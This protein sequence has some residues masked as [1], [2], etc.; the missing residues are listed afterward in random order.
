MASREDAAG[1]QAE[2]F[3]S[4]ARP[5]LRMAEALQ[6]VRGRAVPDLIREAAAALDRF[7]VDLAR[8]GG[9]P[10]AIPPARL[11]LA[12]LLDQGA[13]AN[14]TLDL[15][16]WA[17][18]A[19]RHLFDGRDMTADQ[20][21]DFARR[22]RAAGP[23]FASAAAFLDHCGA[24]LAGTRTRFDRSTGPNWTGM[25][26]VLVLAF[27]AAV[28]GWAGYVEWRF[29][30]Q[31]RAVFAADALAEGL[32]RPGPFPDLAER[33]GRLAEAR[34][35]VAAQ[36]GH[37]PIRLFAGVGGWDAARAAD[38]AYRAA[39]NRHLP[40]A[41]ARAVDDAIATEGDPVTLYDTLRAWAIL[42]GSADFAPDY[43][44][45]WLAARGEGEPL[46]AALAPHV[47]ALTPPFAGLPQP[48]PEL[49][50]QAR[51][52]AA[53]ADEPDRAFL[54]L[55][56]SAGAAGLSG[57]RLPDK[58]PGLADVLQRRSGRALTDPIPGLFTADGWTY[59]RDV[60]AGVAVQTARAEAARLFPG[61]ALASH[62]DTPDLIMARLQGETLDRWAAF[63]GDLRVRPFVDPEAAIMV[64]GRLSA[65]DTPLATLFRDVWNEVGGN[66]RLRAH[67]LQ[68]SVATRFGPM[69]QYVEQGHM[70]DISAIFAALNVALGTIDRDAETGL[71]R[72]MSVQDRA[73]SIAA[74]RQAP[75]VVVQIVEDALAQT[76]EAHA[77]ML[78]NPLTR[79]WQ[80]EVLPLCKTG[81]EGRFPFDPAG[82]DADPATV[83]QLLAPGGALARFF[84]SR[85]EAYIDRSGPE[86][87]WKPE[88]RF[89]GLTPES[90][91]FFRRADAL[92][93]GL[94]APDG[95]LAADFTLTALAAKGEAFVAVGGAGGIVDTGTD[96]L[97]LSWPGTAPEAGVEVS[98]KTPEGEALLKEAGPWGLMRL[99]LPL[100]LRERDDGQR[101]LVDLKTGPARLFVELGF[102]SANN[103]LARR[104]LIRG[105]ACPP[106][107]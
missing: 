34:D 19:L 90:A 58:I 36:A 103:P 27:M 33:L 54:E 60:G 23:D 39:V 35:R 75:T 25:V 65:A 66:D 67:D 80:A 63:I 56:R 99:L 57:W 78:T 50:D 98:F 10:A 7:G 61:A 107:L 4:A 106:V 95:R 86:W 8:A 88:A 64:S 15:A 52:F 38:A 83:A 100:R 43:L 21:A 9:K 32:D 44:A 102:G 77:D 42:S 28:A 62:N 1:N 26:A 97:S 55:L 29:H 17:A 96:S 70:A 48:D 85:A 6:T 72:L 68:I 104:G 22:A 49:M 13:R 3:L 59:A 87:R 51:G 24:E 91:E 73:Q 76:A 101:F 2:P 40:G 84:H 79:A 53:E 74:L 5:V 30:A 31:L 12:L 37:A 20:L 41:L 81:I 69:I 45:G 14:R 93:G 11:A 92:A 16:A 105:F 82:Q 18:G 47:Q 89:S 94:F 46:L 71:Q